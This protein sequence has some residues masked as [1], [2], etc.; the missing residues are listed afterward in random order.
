MKIWKQCAVS[1]FVSILVTRH[2]LSET[3]VDRRLRDIFVRVFYRAEPAPSSV[4]AQTQLLTAY[5]EITTLM[6][7]IEFLNKKITLAHMLP[8]LIKERKAVKEA[9]Q[10]FQTETNPLKMQFPLAHG[11]KFPPITVYRISAACALAIK[12]ASAPSQSQRGQAPR[13]FHN[14]KGTSLRK[15][16]FCRKPL[17]VLLSIF[18][19]LCHLRL[20]SNQ[21]P[22]YLAEFFLSI[23]GQ[24]LLQF[25]MLQL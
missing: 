1:W 9:Y 22:R 2:S 20:E 25:S 5:A 7:T 13:G 10:H 18:K 6:L 17:Q 21:I 3:C 8:S 4:L 15:N 24:D 12:V 16:N 23:C 14:Y 11:K 19:W